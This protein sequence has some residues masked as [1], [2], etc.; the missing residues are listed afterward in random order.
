MF[1]MNILFVNNN[2]ANPSA[3]GI[4]RVTDVLTKMFLRGGHT[5]YYLCEKVSQSQEWVLKYDFPVAVYQLPKFGRFNIIENAS[6]YKS[7]LAKLNID[8][9]VN[10]RGLGG[11]YNDMLSITD[12]KIISVI[13]NRADAPI[14]E[15][16][17]IIIDR[18]SPPYIKIKRLIKTVLYPI[19]S[20]YWRHKITN[21]VTRAYKDLAKYSDIILTLSNLDSLIMD[22]I[23]GVP[24]KAKI[25]SMPNPNTF[26]VEVS[27]INKKKSI[28]YIGRLKKSDKNPMRLLKIWKR[29]YKKHMDWQL[30]I[31]GEGEEKEKMQNYVSR[32]DMTNVYFE[33]RQTNV[34]S[35]YANASILCLVSNFEGRPMVITE[36]MQYGCIPITFDSYGAAREIIDDGVNGC[37]V[38]SFRIKEYANRLSELMDDEEKRVSM[39]RN[40]QKKVKAF[41]AEIVADQW[42]KLLGS[43]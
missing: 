29:I 41:S 38:P 27:N 2:P 33:S 3:G 24:S 43:L 19:I 40:A 12:V 31:V 39:A 32:L 20:A 22:K 10:Q 21:D 34:A 28:L 6:F 36:G 37:L 11:W 17:N 26:D 1:I 42:E 8:V 14:I 23:I 5:V 4:E 9:V 16:P 7:L 18:T 13:H 15:Y 25:L 35:Y 30:I